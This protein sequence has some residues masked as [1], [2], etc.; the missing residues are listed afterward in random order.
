MKRFVAISF[1]LLVT[2]IFGFIVLQNQ[3]LGKVA[4]PQAVL[5]I[6]KYGFSALEPVRFKID[7]KTLSFYNNDFPKLVKK[8]YAVSEGPIALTVIGPDG[9][10]TE[11]I[12]VEITQTGDSVYEVKA[13]PPLSFEPGKYTI[14]VTLSDGLARREITQDF[15]WG[16]LAI[17]T[18]K[19]TYL[20][21]ELA[22]LFIAVLNDKGHMVCD[23]KVKLLI[24]DPVGN[25]Q[26]L[27]TEGNNIKVNPACYKKEFTMESDY[28]SRYTTSV[29]GTY[30]M[31]LTAT[32]S[33]G[34]HSITDSFLVLEDPA[35]DVERVTAT[36]IF[37]PATYPMTLHVTANQDFDGLVQMIVPEEFEIWPLEGVEEYRDVSKTTLTDEGV[38]QN[39]KSLL[40]DVH[41]KKGDTFT[42]GYKYKT[43]LKSPDFYLLGPFSFYE[44]GDLTAEPVFRAARRWQLAIDAD[45]SGTNVVSPTTG[46]VSVSSQ[47]YTFTFTAAETMDSGTITLTV[48]SGWSAPQGT[49]GVAGY[50]TA[51]GSGNAT[52]GTVLNTNDS[53]TGWTEDDTDMCQTFGINTTT[54]IQGTG[55]VLCDN[56]PTSA[57]PDSGDAFSYDYGSGQ[58]WSSLG[59]TQV[60]YWI[61][62]TNGTSGT[63]AAFA[64]G[65]TADLGASFIAQCA[66]PAT[67][68]SG[69]WVYAKCT[70][71]GTITAVRTYGFRCTNA[72]CNPFETGDVYIDELLIGP[73]VPTFSG[74]GPW[75][76]TTRIL[77]AANTETFALTYG[78]GG[79]ASGV[80]NPASPDTYTFTT[81]S[82]TA[83]NGTLTNIAVQPEVLIEDPTPTPTHT[84]TPTTAPTGG[85]TQVEGMQLEGLLFN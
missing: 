77:D 69:V 78:S 64:W 3:G 32:T 39:V 38:T 74:S 53:I 31:E 18:N 49:N 8:V 19:S 47:T 58:N 48:P 22:K 66:V 5:S 61:N 16:V 30:T 60:S 79:G 59:Y 12:P 11:G 62:R 7:L 4:Y 83:V 15:T 42:L 52:V 70:L 27:T 54:K 76:I 50:T 65:T 35:F 81:Q 45:G 10:E 1:V 80:T 29:P 72:T 28:E 71:S 75:T 26:T 2:A 25:K 85:T 24:T 63:A 20:P 84:P 37:P 56:N 46:N 41:V 68:S 6:P 44:D 67:P 57:G 13:V 17:N 34:T 23:A 36:R 14:N 51:V 55:S 82:A 73:G 43:P 21:G 40:W 9:E 33:N